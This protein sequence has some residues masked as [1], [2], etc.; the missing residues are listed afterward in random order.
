MRGGGRSRI[1]TRLYSQIPCYQGKEQGIFQF[2]ASSPL[3]YCHS[4]NDVRDLEQNSLRNRT[5]NYFDG[6]GNQAGENNEF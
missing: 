6:A 2:W 3:R 5:G 1:R 4:A